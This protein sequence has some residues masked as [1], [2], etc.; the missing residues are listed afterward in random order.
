MLPIDPGVLTIGLLLLLFWSPIRRRVLDLL[1]GG[2]LRSKLH[3]LLDPKN[4]RQ[5]SLI[6]M[7]LG[8]V[9]IS[10]Y[11]LTP[12]KK[13]E[14]DVDRRQRFVDFAAKHVPNVGDY[15][16]RLYIFDYEQEDWVTRRRQ[17]FIHATVLRVSP[18]H[19]VVVMIE[20]RG[21]VWEPAKRIVVTLPSGYAIKLSCDSL[22]EVSFTDTDTYGGSNST[23][24]R[25]SMMD[26]WPECQ[27]EGCQ[28]CARFL[29]E[30]LDNQAGAA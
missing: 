30:I 16:A 29:G 14:A 25:L 15:L 1:P 12:A 7:V 26:S 21:G 17:A 8:F 19:M 5:P 18:T 13:A 27:F 28:F 22:D 3:I 4:W 10:K 11:E 24:T 6:L 9:P 20:W 2:P 23:S